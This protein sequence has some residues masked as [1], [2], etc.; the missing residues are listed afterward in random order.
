[1]NKVKA[2]VTSHSKYKIVQHYR[3][4][5]N[6]GDSLL[7]I[8]KMAIQGHLLTDESY[9][10]YLEELFHEQDDDPSIYLSLEEVQ[11]LLGEQQ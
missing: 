11:A 2:L 10:D 9:L 7:F 4:G 6:L 1:M 3:N 8:T 5:I